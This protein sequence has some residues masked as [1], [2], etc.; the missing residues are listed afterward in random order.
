MSAE[1]LRQLAEDHGL[2]IDEQHEVGA[3]TPSSVA[4]TSVAAVGPIA[5]GHTGSLALRATPGGE[6]THTSAV[7]NVHLPGTI[8]RLPQLLCRDAAYRFTKE[9]R[10]DVGGFERLDH[11]TVF[12]SMSVHRRF[13]VEHGG[14]VDAILL[15]RIFIP[16]FLDWLGDHAPENLYFELQ[17]GR[18]A[19]FLAELARPGDLEI[20]WEA[21]ARIVERLTGE[22]SESRRPGEQVPFSDPLPRPPENEEVR[23]ALN[24]VAKVEWK[25]PP[26]DVLE[27]AAAYER[28]AGGGPGAYLRAFVVAGGIGGAFLL[29][30]AILW[31]LGD[32]ITAIPLFALAVGIFVF[33]FPIAVRN[34]RKRRAAELGK[35]AFAREFARVEGLELEDPTAWHERHPDLT[36]PGPVR[37]LWRGTTRD[38]R[39]FRLAL[40]TDAAGTGTRSGYEALLLERGTG[41]PPVLEGGDTIEGDGVVALVRSTPLV[42][43]PTTAGLRNLRR[44]AG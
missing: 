40:L 24:R 2:E 6:G 10:L 9:Y 32:F 1:R 22:L 19:V 20:L 33:L 36:L 12:E 18:L 42:T 11:E 28:H 35:L 23:E 41:E 8:A 44:A 4:M 13:A 37:R 43:G 5:A 39:T 17:N 3:Y 25:E 7:V 16:T 34:P 27:A 29:V 26:A 31:L 38:G 30:G 15:R 14:D 21:A